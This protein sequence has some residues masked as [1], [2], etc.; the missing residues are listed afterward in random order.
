M[1]DLGH[2][3][4]AG[5]VLYE[6][7]TCDITY[8]IQSTLIETPVALPINEPAAPQVSYTITAGM[9]PTYSGNALTSFY[10]IGNVLAGCI[11]NNGTSSRTL[12]WRV[13]RN[14]VSIAN[15]SQSVTANYKACL[16]ASCLVDANKPQIGDTIEIYLWC[17][18]SATDMEL[19]RHALAIYP[20]RIKPINDSN[21]L[22]ANIAVVGNYSIVTAI[23]NFTQNA[24]AYNRGGAVYYDNAVFQSINSSSGITKKFINENA[25]Y[26]L[27]TIYFDT[28]AFNVVRTN[29][30]YYY[31]ES[32][33]FLT[34]V[35]WQETNIRYN[36]A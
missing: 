20:I 22:L 31:Y 17:S 30:A 4:K 15:G 33:Y 29:A 24:A 19:N 34:Q 10:H 8:N 1:L 18:E 26:G 32:I 27:M 28:T 7:K 12:N 11:N 14:G 2:E 5:L 21:Q 25:T 13:K 35:Q 9:F 3:A 23:N 6:Q 36:G 16:N